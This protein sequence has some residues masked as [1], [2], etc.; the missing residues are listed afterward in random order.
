[1]LGD[2]LT[3]LFCLRLQQTKNFCVSVRNAFSIS[4]AL[5]GSTARTPGSN[6]PK[7]STVKGVF[8]LF[9][10]FIRRPISFTS[11]LQPQFAQYNPGLEGADQ[12]CSSL[13][14]DSVRHIPGIEDRTNCVHRTQYGIFQA[15]RIGPI[16]FIVYLRPQHEASRIGP[17]ACIA[18]FNGE[19]NLGR[20][21]NISFWNHAFIYFT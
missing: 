17:I 8:C 5:H 1:M 9:F 21:P 7:F 2:I 19:L 4:L 3:L 16:V 20:P 6:T 10:Q 13:I 15:S 14:H 18:E 12:L 11:R